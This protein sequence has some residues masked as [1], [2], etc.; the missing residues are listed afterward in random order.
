MEGIFY[1]MFADPWPSI[2]FAVLDYERKPKLGYKSLQSAMQPV[3]PSI[4]PSKPGGLE[5]VSWVYEDQKD[6]MTALWVVNDTNETFPNAKLSWQIETDSGQRVT[7]GEIRVDVAP[8]SSKRFWTVPTDSISVGAFKIEV[9][10][11]TQD[12]LVLGENDFSFIILP[13]VEETL[14]LP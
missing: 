5:G 10:L 14:D 7:F 2:S 9:T 3:L 8:D 12:G 6:F 4:F 1:G 11:S 13:N